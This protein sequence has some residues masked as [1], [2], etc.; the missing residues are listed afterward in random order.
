MMPVSTA[1]LHLTHTDFRSQML[2]GRLFLEFVLWAG[3]PVVK[4]GPLTPQQRPLQ[5]RY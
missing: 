4:L 2:W 5:L 3:E 1:A